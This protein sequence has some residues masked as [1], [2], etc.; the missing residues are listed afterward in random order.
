MKATIDT[1]I[2]YHNLVQERRANPQDDMISAL[3]A[4]KIERDSGEIPSLDDLE[5]AGFATLL[6]G[7]G[8]ET[9]T[10]LVGNAVAVFSHNPDQWQ[11]LLDDRSKIGA[12]LA[13]ME[14][15]IALE[16]LL[17]FMPR[18]EVIWEHCKRVTM[19]NVSGWSQLP[20]R[21]LR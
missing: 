21:V 8:A 10:K 14:T 4:A 15:A 1:A 20:V 12:A 17:D 7:A 19:Q 6:G 5:I 2:F 13:R 16:H 9:V 11:K 3:I 18:Y